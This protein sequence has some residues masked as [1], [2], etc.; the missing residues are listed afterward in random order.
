MQGASPS[1]FAMVKMNS[2]RFA[3]CE[4]HPRFIKQLV[5]KA[6][7][8]AKFHFGK[9]RKGVDSPWLKRPIRSSY[10]RMA[11][12]LSLPPPMTR[13]RQSKPLAGL[14]PPM[15]GWSRFM[16]SSTSSIRRARTTGAERTPRSALFISC[17]WSDKTA[18]MAHSGHVI[19]ATLMGAS[20]PISLMAR[21]REASGNRAP[22]KGRSVFPR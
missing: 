3:L 20:A 19:S 13:P 1:S 5:S 8:F 12:T 10:P 22:R 6:A 18:G 2:L 17:R 11:S 14:R 7:A 4:I 9:L 16:A 15:I 21:S